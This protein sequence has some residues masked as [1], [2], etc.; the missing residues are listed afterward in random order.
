[1]ETRSYYVC[2]PGK[3][4]TCFVDQLDLKLLPLP[5]KF[6]DYVM[7]LTSFLIARLT[8]QFTIIMDTHIANTLINV[9][10]YFHCCNETYE[11]GSFIKNIYQ[12]YLGPV[13]EAS[14]SK[15]KA[16]TSAGYHVRAL[17]LHHG[18]V[19]LVLTHFSLFLLLMLLLSLG[20]EAHVKLFSYSLCSQSLTWIHHLP[21][22]NC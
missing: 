16:L 4:G 12:V 8:I 6:W 1:M 10:Q 5:L 22:S 11:A 20:S 3:P 14:K 18:T 9:V 13:L 7:P 19:R 17:L 15:N 21:A 2:I